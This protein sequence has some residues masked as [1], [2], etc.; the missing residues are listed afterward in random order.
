MPSL[1]NTIAGVKRKCD[2]KIVNMRVETSKNL[3]KTTDSKGV[4]WFR[5]KRERNALGQSGA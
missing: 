4:W 3:V 2:K 1:N 5:F